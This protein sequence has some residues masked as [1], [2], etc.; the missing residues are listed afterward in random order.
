MLMKRIL[1]WNTVCVLVR[2]NSNF[3]LIE[4][5][6]GGTYSKHYIINDDIHIVKNKNEFYVI[7]SGNATNTVVQFN[8][9]LYDMVM[10]AIKE[11]AKITIDKKINIKSLKIG[12]NIGN[13]ILIYI[14]I[15]TIIF[16]ILEIR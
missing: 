1:G 3:I 16:I 13:A 12:R 5:T 4:M 6:M 15:I 11:K 8:C 9:V 10:E 7:V 2:T 14:I